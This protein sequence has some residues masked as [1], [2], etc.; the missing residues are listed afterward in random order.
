MCGIAGFIGGG[1]GGRQAQAVLRRMTDAIAH[2]GPDDDGAWHD[3]EAGVALGFRRLS[4]ID[5]SL[6]G[7]QPMASA[8]GRFVT[9]YNGE[10]YNYR[11]LRAELEAAG[12]APLW[13]GHSDTEV[14]LAAIERWGVV[15]AIERLNGMFALAVWDRQRRVLT[16]A[17][18]RLGEKPLYYGRMGGVFLFGSELKAL[19]EHPAFE[20]VVD[21]EALTQFLR[22]NYV[23]VPRSIWR[24]IFKLPPAHFIEIDAQGR[25]LAAP[26]AYWDFG[27]VASAGAADPLPDTPALIDDLETLLKD[28]VLRR[29]EADVPVGAFL[30]GGVDSSAIVALMQAQSARPVRTFTIGF[31]DPQYDEA[32]HAR[33]VAGHLG[34]DHVT[35]NVTGR[36]ALDIVPSLPRMWD[37]PFSD[38]SQIPTHLVSALT[39]RSVTVSLSG[40]GGDEL[41]GG[42]NRYV[43]GLRLWRRAAHLPGPMRRLL[44]RTLQHRFSAGMASAAMR[45]V[46]AR[47][48]QLG[49]A[50]RLPKLGQVIA[51][52][53]PD[54]VYRRLVS[55]MAD[56]AAI[57]IGGAE[58]AGAGPDD[59]GFA[60]FR[61][62]MMYL[63]TLTYLPDDI[64]AKVDRASM[65]VSLEARVPF[66]DHR[67]VEFAWR[68]P[69]SAKIRA[70]KGKWILRALLDRY[71]PRTLID[72]PKMGFAIPIQAWLAGPLRDWAEALLD[73]SRLRAEG[74]FEPASVRRLWSE[75]LRRGGR[76]A[77]LWD[78]LMFQAWWADQ[79]GGGAAQSGE[80]AAPAAVRA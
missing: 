38:S 58:P 9:I 1:P 69:M 39:R 32:D 57:V 74:F 50:D 17:R 56:P 25:T 70:G 68:L 8:S 29:M 36:D 23:P 24:G 77:Q 62:T 13:R 4:I 60:D 78:L 42:Y 49:L 76:H 33:A 15:G 40:D 45:A 37:E 73:E 6:A 21:R 27:A 67:L 19:T 53:S 14:M 11:D 48:R 10:I 34:T 65:A 44:A 20:R 61:Q 52:D 51:E 47:H 66:L 71:V 55:H 28:A 79:G 75:Q 30:S 7:H 43:S 54:A 12:A 64:L 16:L 31:D 18:D 59:P 35:L 26:A 72:R 22:Y 5:L 63:D 80:V 46:P 2:R 41:F 3:E